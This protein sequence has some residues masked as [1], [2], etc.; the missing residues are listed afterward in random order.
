MGVFGHWL[1]FHFIRYFDLSLTFLFNVAFSECLKGFQSLMGLVFWSL[2]S[3][4][5][6]SFL[7]FLSKS[8]K[9]LSAVIFEFPPSLAQ[10]LS[11]NNTLC[12]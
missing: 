10:A 12:Y 5:L 7:S 1:G 6:L 11:D 9:L 2:F 4:I 8:K 3:S